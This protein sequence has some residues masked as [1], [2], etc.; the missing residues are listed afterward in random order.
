MGRKPLNKLRVEN[1]ELKHRWLEILMPV[2]SAQGFSS[3]TMDEMAKLIGVSK[4]TFYKYFSSKEELIEEIISW[5]LS[6]ISNYKEPLLD[7]SLG[8]EER[9]LKA[10]EVSAS[11][12]TD[13]STVFLEDL[14][15]EFPQKWK[16]IED[17]KNIALMFLRDFYNEA[18][19]AG[20][21]PAEFSPDVMVI[22]DRLVFAGISDPDLLK[23][24]GLSLKQFYIHYFS[25]KLGG[26]MPADRY[27]SFKG[28]LES[29]VKSL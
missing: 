4:A 27:S 29:V 8:Y 28:R 10:V 13:I 11:A 22:M 12:M 5:K 20:F 25:I 24:H 18:S 21:F 2:F 17:F 6:E 1:P 19:R 23:K 9:F 16:M 15:N 26:I 3:F 7:K 14:K